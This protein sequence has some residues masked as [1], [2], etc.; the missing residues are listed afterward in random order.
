[1]QYVISNVFEC[2]VTDFF[3]KF[4]QTPPRSAI[5][6]T[7]NDI[8][9]RAASIVFDNKSVTGFADKDDS[10]TWT[11]DKLISADLVLTLL[12]RISQLEERVRQLGG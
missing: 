7:P 12:N 2:G 5:V 1:M 9:F 8:T 11:A 6:Q 10:S 3:S 4:Q